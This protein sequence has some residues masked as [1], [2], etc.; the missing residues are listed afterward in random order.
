MICSRK[1]ISNLALGSNVSQLAK[2]QQIDKLSAEVA[3]LIAQDNFE[4]VSEKLAQR[5]SIMKEVADN[6]LSQ[7]DVD[8]KQ[9]LRQFLTKCQTEDNQQVEQLLQERTKVLADSQKQSKI[10]QAVNAYQQFS[11]K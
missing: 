3:A 8:D 10:K 1:K 5:L 6:V 11:E 9:Q 2:Y 7:G 4:L